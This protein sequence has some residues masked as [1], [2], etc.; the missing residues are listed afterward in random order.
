[1]TKEEK[2]LKF[3][4]GVYDRDLKVVCA[5]VDVYEADIDKYFIELANDIRS[6]YYN[7]TKRYTCL[8]IGYFAIEGYESPFFNVA[9]ET[10]CPLEKYIDKKRI[11]YQR[12]IQVLNYLPN[13][14]FKMPEEMQKEV[15]ADIKQAVSD[16]VEKYAD[17]D[18]L[19]KINKTSVASA[20]SPNKS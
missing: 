6:P 18:K 17:I 20:K 8:K 13:G 9:V 11:E 4:V 12:I 15:Q 19:A 2:N 14:Y 3:I 7:D 5:C 1:M 10:L 16:Y